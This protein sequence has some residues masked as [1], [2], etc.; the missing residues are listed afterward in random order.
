MVT[1]GRWGLGPP[2]PAGAAWG[3]AWVTREAS[4]FAPGWQEA[5]WSLTTPGLACPA[6]L[7]LETMTVSSSG[8]QSH[9]PPKL[10][11][12]AGAFKRAEPVAGPAAGPR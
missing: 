5:Q 3:A 11:C 1:V 8:P 6:Q 4:A 7:G 2:S 10:Y 12:F 9:L